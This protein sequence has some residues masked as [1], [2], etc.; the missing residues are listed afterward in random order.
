[1]CS[2]V[3]IYTYIHAHAFLVCIHVC[4]CRFIY[5]NGS[6][7]CIPSLHTC[8]YMSIYIYLYVCMYTVHGDLASL[9]LASSKSAKMNLASP[10]RT[11]VAQAAYMWVN[12]SVCKYACVSM[13]WATVPLPTLLCQ[14]RVC[15]RHILQCVCVMI[16][17]LCCVSVGYA[18]GTS[19][20]AYAWWF[21]LFVVSV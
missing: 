3:H 14:C 10:F 19:Y 15:M 16:P 5:V 18:C 17:A 4:I 9:F 7:Q 13:T 2:H 12:E 8:M 11:W 21:Q 20:N 6:G 1:M